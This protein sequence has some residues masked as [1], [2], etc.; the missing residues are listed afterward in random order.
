M[1]KRENQKPWAGR[2]KKPMAKS[3]EEFSS[4]IH[5]DKRL[6]KHDIIGSIAYAKALHKAKVLTGSEC[7]KMVK[8]LRTILQENEK[9]K[10]KFKVDFEDVHM[11][12]EKILIDRV[13]EIGKKLHTGRSRNDQ[14]ST[15]LRMYLKEEIVNT[16]R[17]IKNL[18]ATLLKLAEENIS[19]IMPGY[20]HL[21]RAQPILFSHYLMAYFEMLERDKFRFLDSFH[22]ADSLPLG[23]AALAGTNFHI[24][25][26]FLA[27]ELA[28]ANISN[29]SMDAVSDRDFVADY[30]YAASMCMMHLSRFA[31]EIIIWSTYEF[32]F[33]E[34]SDAYSTGSSLM[35]QKKN[36]DIAEL[37]RGKTG[38]VYG[39]L[40]AIITIMKG[41]PLAY[42]RDMQEDKEPLFDA[43]D[44]LKKC[45]GIFNEM[46]ST[47]K[48]H[49]DKM[50]NAATKGFLTAT[51]LAYYLVRKNVPFRKAHEIVGKIIAYCEE[52]N[53]QLDYISISE[54]KKFS[55]K[56]S[57]DA[58]RVLSAESSIAAKDV[59]GGTSTGRVKE[60]IQNA[61]K[62]IFSADKKEE[63]EVKK[64]ESAVSK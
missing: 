22:R 32:D 37:V 34:L 16:L 15:A 31:E 17:L 51:D 26:E 62:K 18:Q 55:D 56:F 33:I 24:D 39:S 5:F 53:M 4:S 52:S 6:I 60:A 42:N 12:V 38:R 27:R 19:V 63:A 10:I 1:A 54:L 23:S 3:A 64:Q 45:L 20:T 14:V 35:P 2:F 30:I 41:L 28:F 50:K 49:E 40:M 21:Q 7:T 36:P 25:R 59:I 13:G 8:A 46:I 9:G 61:K 47:L 44:T 43:I 58:S 48:V 11:N 57:Y 29:N